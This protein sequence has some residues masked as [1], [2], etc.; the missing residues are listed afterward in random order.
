MSMAHDKYGELT[1]T[2]RN[3]TTTISCPYVYL[4]QVQGA[5][6]SK[7]SDVLHDPGFL[8]LVLTNKHVFDRVPVDDD[9]SMYQVYSSKTHSL[10]QNTMNSRDGSMT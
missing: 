6:T 9:K 5:C 8:R 10:L 4:T 3:P 7:A 2:G 1:L